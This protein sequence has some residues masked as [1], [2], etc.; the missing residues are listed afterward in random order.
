[1]PWKTSGYSGHNGGTPWDTVVI[2]W[3]TVRYVQYR[4]KSVRVRRQR[5]IPWKV[6]RIPWNDKGRQWDTVKSLYTVGYRGMS[7]DTV[8]YVGKSMGW[9]SQ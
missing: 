4:R 1:M 9:Y 6:C 8:I 7:V 2:R 5:G 3:D